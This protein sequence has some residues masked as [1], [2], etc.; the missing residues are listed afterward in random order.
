MKKIFIALSLL[1]VFNCEDDLTN[2]TPVFQATV[3]GNNQWIAEDF[4]ATIQNNQLSISGTNPF[5]VISFVVNSPE[6]SGY[7]FYSWTDDYAIF[8]DTLQ[9]STQND[10]IGSIAFLSDGYLDIQEID[11]VN[12]LDKFSENFFDI[13]YVDGDHKDP[14]VSLDIFNSFKILKKDGLL[15]VD[16]LYFSKRKG[17]IKELIGHAPSIDGLNAL[18][19]LSLES[20]NEHHLLVKF[21]GPKNH[22]YNPMVG[23]MRKK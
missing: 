7:N 17:K 21:Y 4:I 2:K 19:K 11:S 10:G 9:Y 1:V 15:L 14:V 12:I 8:Q 20:Q 22:F 5:G 18:K 6:V 16:D 23:I 13:V 3:N